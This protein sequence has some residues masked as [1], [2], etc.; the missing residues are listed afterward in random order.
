[1]KIYISAATKEIAIDQ[2]IGKDVWVKVQYRPSDSPGWS[3]WYIRPLSNVDGKL[4]FNLCGTDID[5]RH[6]TWGASTVAQV[7]K[8][9][10][11][12]RIEFIHIAEPLD[13]LSTDEIITSL[14]DGNFT[15]EDDFQLPLNRGTEIN[16]LV[17]DTLSYAREN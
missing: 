8:D 14:Y 13:V 10:T 5:W 3:E 11:V 7:L 2:F 1:M 16:D 12:A 15:D 6:R 17:N 9:L 4:T